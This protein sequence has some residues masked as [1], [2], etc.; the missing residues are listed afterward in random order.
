MT[1]I[2]AAMAEWRTK[3]CIQFK[4][5]TNEKAYVL[6]RYSNRLVG[7]C[8]NHFGKKIKNLKIIARPEIR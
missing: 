8:S 3:T 2:K 7:I 1:A 5:R 4:K 6:F